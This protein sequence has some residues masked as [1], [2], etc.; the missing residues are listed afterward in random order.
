VSETVVVVPVPDAEALVGALRRRHTEDGGEGMP[1]HVTLLAPFVEHDRLDVP[2]FAA[3]LARFPPFHLALRRLA[4]FDGTPAVLYATRTRAPT[5]TWSR[6]S[7]S[8][9][10]TRRCSTGSRPRWPARCL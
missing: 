3:E 6:T 1:A 5:T 7:P 9:S 10:P 8:P 4:R 2:T